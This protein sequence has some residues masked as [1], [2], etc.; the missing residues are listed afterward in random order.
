MPIAN[1]YCLIKNGV[2]QNVIVAG[3]D[4]AVDYA[5]ENGFEA[6]QRPSMAVGIDHKYHDGKFWQDV[7]ELDESGNHTGT[8]HEEE[9][10]A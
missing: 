5:D 7:V 2:V 3:A 9:I 4:F 1:E 8:T 6:V 10:T